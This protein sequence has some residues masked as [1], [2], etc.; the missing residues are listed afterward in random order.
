MS[1]CCKLLQRTAARCQFK[2]CYC[3]F[4]PS[5]FCTSSVRQ[6][7]VNHLCV[8]W[9][10]KSKLLVPG[11]AQVS[12]KQ[13]KRVKSSLVAACLLSL[14]MSS[15]SALLWGFAQQV[16]WQ[17]FNLT[18]AVWRLL[19]T[20]PWFCPLHM[21]LLCYQWWSG[22]RCRPCRCRTAW[23]ETCSSEC[24]PW[25]AS[26]GRIWAKEQNGRSSESRRSEMTE[27]C[28]SFY[29]SDDSTQSMSHQLDQLHTKLGILPPELRQ[30]SYLST[31][32]TVM[33]PADDSEGSLTGNAGITGFIGHPV[34]RVYRAI[35][36]S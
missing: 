4:I 32:S 1:L 28:I 27:W 16:Q 6:A 8:G 2:I 26:P 3:L 9:A 5:P 14:L 7:F 20:Q 29:L 15:L 13:Q 36:N 33:L 23:H 35:R 22:V 18:T 31:A 21:F 12:P 34:W 10:L 24:K 19:C 25:R 30:S 17:P 11:D